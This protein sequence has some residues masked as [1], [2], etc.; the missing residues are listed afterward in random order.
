[1]DD[2]EGLRALRQ[3]LAAVQ[4]IRIEHERKDAIIAALR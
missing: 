1:G 3:Q 4:R 2:E